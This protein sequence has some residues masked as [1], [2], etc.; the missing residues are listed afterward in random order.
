MA[1]LLKNLYNEKYVSL[2]AKNVAL[3]YAKF[4]V[5][6]F[7]KDVFYDSFEELELKERMRRISATMGVYLPSDY[8]ESI[9]ILKRVFSSM[10]HSFALQNIIFQDY[11]EVFG[12]DDFEISMDALESFTKQSS[13]EFAIRKFIL[14]YPQR[15]MERMLTWATSNDA[16]VRRLASE[17]CR[18]RLPWAIALTPFKE[19][20]KQVLEILEILKD[21]ESEYVRKSV[22]NNLNDVSKDNPEILKELTRGWIGANKKRDALLKHGCRTLLKNG[23]AE[24]LEL[25]GFNKPTSIELKNFEFTRNVKLEESLDFVFEII[26]KEPLGR[27][28]VEYSI[29][30]LRKNA[31]SNA[32]VFQISQ[33]NVLEKEKKISKSHSFKKISTRTYYVGAHRVSIIINGVSFI[34]KEFTLS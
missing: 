30:F 4:N 32:K 9:E 29:D 21:D 11:V 2:L 34:T 27:I 7:K 18:P 17:G 20:P 5:D 16:H 31:K 14:K 24:T 3:V 1:P 8:A 6:G 25:F 13:S 15:A 19:N 23:D 33:A 28:R 12:L 22:A 10:N 26:S